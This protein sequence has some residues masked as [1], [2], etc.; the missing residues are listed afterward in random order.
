MSVIETVMVGAHMRGTSSLLAS[1]LR[2][3]SVRHE[4]NV[5]QS[6]ARE[7]IKRV[8]IPPDIEGRLTGEL[9]YGLQRRVEMAR[10]LATGA[11]LLLLDE[12]A[13][14]LNAQETGD[15]SALIGDLA[16]DGYTIILV[17]HDMEMIMGI[18]HKIVVMNLGRKIAEGAPADVQTDPHVIEAY[19]GSDD[20]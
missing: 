11:R 14:G 6:C 12:P 2:L 17:E 9:A 19:L 18:S 15:I 16:R 10:A 7:A 4:E 1:L 20:E 3:K 8:G 13:A 5:L